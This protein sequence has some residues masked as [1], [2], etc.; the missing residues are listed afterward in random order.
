MRSDNNSPQLIKKA[1]EQENSPNIDHQSNETIVQVR[2]EQHEE[3]DLITRSQA[4]RLLEK[5]RTSGT[6]I[7][8]FEGVNSIGQAF[9][10]EIFRVFANQNSGFEFKTINTNGN[11]RQMI[12]RAVSTTNNNCNPIRAMNISKPK[13]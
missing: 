6:V 2:L 7:F 5:L 4:K 11:V 9:A 8:D 3:D 12:N 10:D 1:S 13:K